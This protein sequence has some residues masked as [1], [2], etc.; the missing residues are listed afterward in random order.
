LL[1]VPVEEFQQ[2]TVFDEIV[3]PTIMSLEKLK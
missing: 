1:D 3:S 2:V